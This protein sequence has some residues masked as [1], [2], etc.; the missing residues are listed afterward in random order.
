MLYHLLFSDGRLAKEKL[1]V[2]NYKYFEAKVQV[3]DKIY[4]LILQAEDLKQNKSATSTSSLSNDKQE[5]KIASST[6]DE[7]TT[8][9]T[10]DKSIPLYLYDLYHLPFSEGRLA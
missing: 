8:L 4:T 7:D 1:D 2:K 3:F 10:D 6:L 5:Y 9:N